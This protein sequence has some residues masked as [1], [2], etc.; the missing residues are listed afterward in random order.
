MQPD[1]EARYAICV[2]QNSNK[3]LLL[4]QRS[5][6]RDLGAEL[7]GFPGGHIEAHESP[8][9]CAWRELHE[10]I[11]PA[12]QVH[13]LKVAGPFRNRHYGG[14]FEAYLFLFHWLSGVI[15]LDQEH[16][17][18]EWVPINKLTYYPLMPGITDDLKHLDIM[19]HD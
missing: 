5:A 16:T 8:I 11:G 15:A 12:N 9:E 4:V 3:E 14:R 18:Y 6:H 10:E 1:P 7:W 17:T 2:V 19:T 13:L